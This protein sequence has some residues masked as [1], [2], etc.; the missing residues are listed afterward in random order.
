MSVGVAGHA[1]MLVGGL[2]KNTQYVVKHPG[3]SPW[4]PSQSRSPLGTS[5][6]S[7]PGPTEPEHVVPK[8]LDEFPGPNT[9]GADPEWHAP[10]PSCGCVP[11]GV[12]VPLAHL[13]T[14]S[15]VLSGFPSQSLSADDVQSRGSGS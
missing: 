13:H 5:H 11:H 10:T 8:E 4:M 3:P 9:H 7:V 12:D 1:Q 14:E 15:M 2:L 6:V